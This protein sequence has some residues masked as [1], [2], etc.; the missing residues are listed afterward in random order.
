MLAKLIAAHKAGR[1][2]FF[3]QHAYLAERKAFAAYLAPLRKR[4]AHSR[5]HL[6][7]QPIPHSIVRGILRASPP[8]VRSLA[9]FGRRPPVDVAPLS[10]A[11]IR[12][13]ARLL[14]CARP[15]EF[16][17]PLSCGAFFVL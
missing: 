7:P 8:R 1:L 16:K 14:I 2:T 11:G 9:A 15:N 3:G 13:P 6:P 4:P 12:N 17:A 5:S 10:L